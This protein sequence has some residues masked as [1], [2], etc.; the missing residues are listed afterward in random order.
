MAVSDRAR[1]GTGGTG[2]PAIPCARKPARLLAW[3]GWNRWNKCLFGCV[4]VVVYAGGLKPCRST[5]A[6][7]AT[8]NNPCNPFLLFHKVDLPK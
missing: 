6:S 4:V 3:N 5:A 7:T 1:L 2:G 8:E